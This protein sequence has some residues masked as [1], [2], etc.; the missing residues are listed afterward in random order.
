M[1]V[2]IASFQGNTSK[3]GVLGR[4]GSSQCLGM[5][6]QGFISPPSL[7][8]PLIFGMHSEKE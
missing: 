2:G 7:S 3:A 5:H 1:S 4:L 6:V 8:P